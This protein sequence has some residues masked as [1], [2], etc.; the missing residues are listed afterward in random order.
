MKIRRCSGA[1]RSG[2][3]K[4]N[5]MSRRNRMIYHLTR[6]LEEKSTV[7]LELSVECVVR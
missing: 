7:S 2:Q 4:G 6:A 1:A 5:V 3:S